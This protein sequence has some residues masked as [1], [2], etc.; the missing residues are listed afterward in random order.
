ML[1]VWNRLGVP[2]ILANEKDGRLP[3]LRLGCDCQLAVGQGL[4]CEGQLAV[5]RCVGGVISFH[6]YNRHFFSH[7]LLELDIPPPV[8]RSNQSV[9]L[10]V[11]AVINHWEKEAA[12]SKIPDAMAPQLAEV[13]LPEEVD[14]EVIPSL[15]VTVDGVANAAVTTL[16]DVEDGGAKSTSKRSRRYRSKK[17]RICP[18][19]SNIKIP[20]IL[21]D[22]YNLRLSK[23]ML[24]MPLPLPSCL[25]VPF[26]TEEELNTVSFVCW[27]GASIDFLASQYRF[28]LLVSSSAPLS[29][30]TRVVACRR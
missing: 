7:K 19:M 11:D 9:V 25:R 3:T 28:A 17:S 29:P 24:F 4:P 13:V 5:S 14:D 6:S 22:I 20:F 18:S 30:S 27:H 26:T 10:N 23:N 16:A 21:R 15:V 1:A 2:R 12:P 8:F